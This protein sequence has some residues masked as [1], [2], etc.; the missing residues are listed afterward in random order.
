M[1]YS[2]SLYL[3]VFV[4][5]GSSRL[6]VETEDRDKG[7]KKRLDSFSDVTYFLLNINHYEESITDADSV[8]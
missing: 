7:L 3:C 8:R 4:I 6:E 5:E 1:I 2:V